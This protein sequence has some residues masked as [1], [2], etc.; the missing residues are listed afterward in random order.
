MIRIDTYRFVAITNPYV[1]PLGVAAAAQENHPT[2]GAGHR[3]AHSAIPSARSREAQGGPLRGR[4]APEYFPRTTGTA[5]LRAGSTAAGPHL[6]SPVETKDRARSA[7][8][9]STPVG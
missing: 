8:L 7:P 1:S 4:H 6:H 9:H 5:P 2:C 3:P